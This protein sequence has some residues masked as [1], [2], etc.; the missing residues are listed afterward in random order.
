MYKSFKVTLICLLLLNFLLSRIYAQGSRVGTT[1]ASFLELGMG[2]VGNAMGESQVL[3]KPDISSI[4][5]NPASI[6]YLERNEVQFTYLPW[7]L[8]IKSSFVVGGYVHPLLGTFAMSF[9]QTS[10]GEEE[11]TTVDRQNGTG[12]VYDGQDMAVALSYGR[13][14]VQGFSFGATM[15]YIRSQIYHETA[16][17]VAVDLGAIVHTSFFSWSET[18][19]DGLNIGMSISNYGTRMKYDG[20]DL[21]EIIDTEPDE[22]GNYAFIPTRFET[23]EWELPLIAR[24]GISIHP[25]IAGNHRLTVITDFLHA[26]NNNEYINFGAQYSFDYPGIGK[27]FFRGGYKGLYMDNSEYGLTLGF[28]AVLYYI[29]NNALKFDY[30]YRDVGILGGMNT[31]TVGF[32][33]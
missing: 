23:K 15:K 9:L 16:S 28:G 22:N 5:Y 33:F 25:Y 13:E 27:M 7:I 26:N 20:I 6:G 12:E 11:V 3:F 29:G 21:R 32:M 2:S 18:P 30:S 31:F 10:F 24:I 4:Y 8:D 19:G 1:T 17:A 14:I